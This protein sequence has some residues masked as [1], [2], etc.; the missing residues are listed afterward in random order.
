MLAFLISLPASVVNV[1]LA[2]RAEATSSGTLSLRYKGFAY[3][4]FYNHAYEDA[5]SLAGVAAT[6]A[7]AVELTLE[8]GIDAVHS[9][10]VT[11]TNYTDSLTALGN[12]ID[13]ANALGLKVMVRPLID[14]LDPS[15]TGPYSVGDWRQTY[16]PSD[17]STFFASY[18]QM[19]VAQAQIAQQHGAQMVSI[20][21]ELDQLAN[22]PYASYW[23]DIIAAMRDAFNGEL[24]YSASWNTAAQVS[25]WSLLDYEGIDC[26]IP[27]SI[28]SNPSVQALVDGWTQTAT[29]SAN[30]N[31]YSE[32]G[33]QSP[34]QYFQSLAMQSGKPLLFT[35]IGYANDT[36]AAGD[37]SADNNS[38]DPTLQA[39]LYQA[40]FDAWS[41]AG[42]TSLVGIFFWEWDPN[43]SAS[44]VGPNID[45]FSPQNSP[46][47]TVVTNGF[48]AVTPL[49]I[50]TTA[51]LSTGPDPSVFGQPVIF[52]ATVIG[53]GA[54]GTVTFNDGTMTLG[55]SS[56]T[57]GTASFTASSLSVA[58]HTI[59]AVYG[60]DTNFSGATS[61]A[62]TQTVNPIAT[63][64]VVSSSAASIV[65]GQ[66]V[67]LMAT[68]S[69][70]GTPAGSVTF[71]DGGT[72][73]GTGTLSGGVATLTTSALV[74]GSHS[75]TAVYAANGNYAGSTSGV[76]TEMVSK[77][78]TTAAVGAVPNPAITGQ[79]VV[80]TATLAV[81]SPA[82]GTPTGSV[83]FRDGTATI[84]T[85]ALSGLSASLAT[86]SLGVGSHSITAVYGGDGN[87][88][89]A[90]S[91]AVTVTI[92]NQTTTTVSIA[93][94]ATPSATGQSVTFTATITA[95]GSPT[96][97]VSFLDGTT[98]IGSGTVSG[99]SASFA[100]SSLGV[101][102]HSMTA[103]YSGDGTFAGST[104]A[105]LTQ[106][107]HQPCL[108]M[109]GSA[110]AISGS[111][112]S[113]F[114]SNVG[115]TGE[116]GEPD[117]T[118]DST[119]FHSVWCA[120]SAPAAGQAVFDTA[121]SSFDTT[122]GIYTGGS[123]SALTLVAANDNISA[124]NLQSR[125]SFTATAGTT[126]FIDLDGA[127]GATGNYY[128]NW[129]EAA[130]GA[131]TFASILPSARSVLTGTT[132]TAFGSI[133]NSGSATATACSLA[134]P[135]GF[136]GIFSYQTT[137]ASN[138]PS[139][140]A[141][142]PADIGGGASQ[143]YVFAITPLQDLN[144][145]N[146]AIVFD[147]TNTPPV[148]TVPGLN[149][150]LLSASSVPSPDLISIGSTPT[151]DG[152]LD[153][154][155]ATG[156]AAFAAATIDIG[157][158][159]QITATVD[160][161]GAGLSLIA[162]L[163]QSNPATAACANPSSPA[164]S[165]AVSVNTNDVLTFTIFVTGTGTVPFDPANNRLFLN[166]KTPDGITRG[167]TSVAVRT[168]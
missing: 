151:N 146:V 142:T 81:V 116:P 126:Y 72:A 17:T 122:L 14:F 16:Q 33:G 96:G 125:V 65:V 21:A 23:E 99:G 84:G 141:N 113:V 76:F 85:G 62:V 67:T 139:G 42:P 88:N 133:I 159:G 106:L 55:V 34:I 47:Q 140:T 123:V 71:Q 61:S 25:F 79:S 26:Y 131:L 138:L 89:G 29:Q 160:D 158:A 107:V 136:P 44:N 102:T 82:M 6:G 98:S 101:G 3:P 37:P 154:P 115:A 119:P 80:I 30:P 77:G 60:G 162:T 112:G 153:I 92:N 120:W 121:G 46:A 50:S 135:P 38:V 28:A 93:S 87:F 167:A 10:V 27:L 165:V 105:P 91:S 73:I 134:E 5:D 12:A 144:S 48:G 150:L 95:S 163:C 53:N 75:I 13:E 148:V 69:G 97:T 117:P 68:V 168:Q 19:I 78:D 149:T 7:N 56:L 24:T 108:D 31:A 137:D 9:Q 161:N 59:T 129:A 58:S 104:S 2:P 11:D 51:N 111:N 64:A 152:I 132:A 157:A 36:G 70:G 147:C 15:V 74:T 63:S 66:A 124:S 43:S 128:L 22:A 103:V 4:A 90:T 83:T 8:F 155:G 109:F 39:N 35:E 52:T 40:F 86:S 49:K 100:T 32:I 114:G 143:S 45:S 156:S 110:A 94:S 18:K 164:S 118:G 130:A 1:V 57:S 54:T 20:G 127:N 166:F 41:Q 145:D